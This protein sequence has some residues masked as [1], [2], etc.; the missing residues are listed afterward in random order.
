MPIIVLYTDV[1]AVVYSFAI[2]LTRLNPAANCLRID[3]K[4]FSGLGRGNYTGHIVLYDGHPQ[5]VST[6]EENEKYMGQDNIWYCFDRV[7]SVTLLDLHPIGFLSHEEGK[8]R[9]QPSCARGAIVT[10][11]LGFVRSTLKVS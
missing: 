3:A 10:M 5:T 1:P 9:V 7:V 2:E 11:T 8:K 4:M 6:P